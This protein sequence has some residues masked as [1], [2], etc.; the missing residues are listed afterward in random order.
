MATPTKPPARRTGLY[1]AIVIALVLIVA[2]VA[3]VSLSSKGTTTTSATSPTTST[4]ST[5]T[6]S[7]S[8]TCTGTSTSQ[9][10]TIISGRTVVGTTGEV[11][12]EAQCP[13]G[14]TGTVVTYDYGQNINIAVTVPNNLTPVAIQTVLD[15]TPQNTNPWNVTS[16]GRTYVLG[17]GAAGESALTT[18]GLTHDVYSIVTFA[19]NSTAS[20]NVV[21]FSIIG[22]P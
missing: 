14:Q 4:T 11:S 22:G 13:G 5:I 10:I 2:V 3:G 1:A 9:T 12:E 19:D 8:V 16:T 7:T 15:G 20:S 21:Y 6:S 18:T 17:F